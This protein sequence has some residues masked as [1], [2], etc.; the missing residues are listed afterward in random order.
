[1]QVPIVRGIFFRF[2]GWNFTA[3][4]SIVFFAHCVMARSESSS[5]C[6]A[7]TI[8]FV[9]PSTFTTIYSRTTG[10]NRI[11]SSSFR[12]VQI[13]PLRLCSNCSHCANNGCDGSLPSE[14]SIRTRAAWIGH[15]VAY[16]FEKPAHSQA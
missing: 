7:A 2:T 11:I 8:H 5:Q 14:N 3:R 12:F 6:K 10:G 16:F 13:K 15:H 1:M 9:F 4:R